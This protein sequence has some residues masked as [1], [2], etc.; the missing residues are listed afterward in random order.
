MLEGEEVRFR[1]E[2]EAGR[3]FNL[4]ILAALGS[5]L[6]VRPGSAA[7][8]TTTPAAARFRHSFGPEP[9]ILA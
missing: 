8:L 2:G 6:H 9:A 1:V 7:S 3:K 4:K 5:R